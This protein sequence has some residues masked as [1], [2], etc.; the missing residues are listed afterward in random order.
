MS[1]DK[2]RKGFRPL[3][4][5]A[6]AG[7]VATISSL[8]VAANAQ[9]TEQKSTPATDDSVTALETIIVAGDGNSAN[10]NTAAFGSSRLPGTVK[11]TPQIVNTVP[12]KLIVEQNITTLEQALRNVPGITVAIGEGNGG[13]NGDR[14]RIR[15]FEAIGDSYRDGLRDFGVYVRDSFNMEQVQ[16]LKGPSGESFGVGTTGGA[17]S[18]TSKTARLGTFGSADVSVGNGPLVRSTI[19]YN[20]QVDDT[21]AIRFNAMGNRQDIVDRDTVKSDRW[22]GG[23]DPWVSGLV[24]TPAGLSTT[25]TS[26]TIARPTMV[27][28]WPPGLQPVPAFVSRSPSSAFR[29][30]TITARTPT[31]TVRMSTC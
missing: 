26:R 5:G 8:P 20:R 3:I 31:A 17:I 1:K 4:S 30:R 12:E 10:A 7:L 13:P 6:S 15:G 21:T 16:V 27:C 18:T 9:S 22:G 28:R 2:A 24:P 11:D 23:P 29:A 14:F 19:D 25:C